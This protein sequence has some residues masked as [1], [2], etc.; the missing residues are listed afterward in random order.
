MMSGQDNQSVESQ[1]AKIKSLL[2]CPVCLD[3][4]RCLPPPSCPSGHIVCLP[5]KTRLPHCPIVELPNCPTCRQP[6]PVNMINSVVGA[7]IEQVEHSCKY[8]DQGC[9][10]KMMLKDLL[11]HERICLER[12]VRVPLCPY[13]D[14]ESNVK[15]KDIIG[16]V[17]FYCLLFSYVF[18]CFETIGREGFFGGF[19]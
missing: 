16:I 7:I 2:K 17:F 4:P 19:P 9:E 5:C 14:C 11:V 12:T 6:M 8:S 15:L 18:W 1:M 10:V 3:I 13:N